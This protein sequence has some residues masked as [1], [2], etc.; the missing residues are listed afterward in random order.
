MIDFPAMPPRP[1]FSRDGVRVLALFDG[2]A[3]AMEAL[4]LAD[5]PVREY[6]GIENDATARA[7]ADFRYPDLIS[8]PCHDVREFAGETMRR[9]GRFDL[10][11]GGPPCVGVSSANT[12]LRG[13]AKLWESESALVV[14]FVRI[15]EASGGMFLC[16]NVASM[17]E[18]NAGEYSRLLGSD[19]VELNQAAFGAQH[20]ERL[21]WWG[22][23]TE[24]FGR[25]GITPPQKWSREVF[26]RCVGE[27]RGRG[28]AG[29]QAL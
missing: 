19:Y 29:G 21:F 23:A 3:M 20:R 6:V 12:S 8:R 7:L 5:I 22:G 14:E 1:R 26:R 18:A 2:A 15:A 28:G 9:A 16:E 17:S 27:G 11:I 10:V 25:G 4:A 24:W 13:S